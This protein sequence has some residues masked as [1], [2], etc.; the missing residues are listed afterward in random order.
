MPVDITGGD[1]SLFWKAGI[2]TSDFDKGMQQ[3]T[4]QIQQSAK[5]QIQIQQQAAQS[6]KQIAQTI[7][8]SAGIIKGMDKDIELQVKN[9]SALQS[10]IQSLKGQTVQLNAQGFDTI[11]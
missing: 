9:L 6:Q 8:Q 5:N 4:D 2:D 7:L 10:Q 3:I 1:G 11:Q